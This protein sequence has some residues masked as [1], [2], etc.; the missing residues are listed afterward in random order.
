MRHVGRAGLHRHR[1]AQ[2]AHRGL[3]LRRALADAVRHDRQ[4]VVREQR[5]AL[6]LVQE[7]VLARRQR[8]RRILGPLRA[9][10]SHERGVR[11]DLRHGAEGFLFVGEGH[12]PRGAERI[13]D[14]RLRG[15]DGDRFSRGRG[16]CGGIARE[17]LDVV[18][19]ASD[20]DVDEEKVR[21]GILREQRQH[22]AEQAAVLQQRR[23]NVD[24]VRGRRKPRQP[25]G[26]RGLRLRRE[27]GERKAEIFREV[28]GHHAARARIA[29]YHQPPAFGSPALQV[30][31]GGESHGTRVAHAPD[32][33][34]AKKG[35]DH[36]VFVGER[37]GVRGRRLLSA[38]RARGFHRDDRYVAAV[39]IVGSARQQH[40]V[41]DGL[42]VKEDQL[43]LR[44]VRHGPRHVGDRDVR[45]V[46]R[47]VH[48]PHADAAAAH[49]PVYHLA[50][51]AALAHHR[52][53]PVLRLDLGEEGR[54][55]RDRAGAEVGEALGV[56]A[57][58]AHSG[59]A[60][61]L[62]HRPL[63]GPALLARLA[64]A[65]GEDHRDSHAPRGALVHSGDR[66]VAAHDDEHELGHLRQRGERGI[67][68]QPLDLGAV[69]IDRIDRAPEAVALHVK[70]RASA[71]L[72]RILRGADD[73][74][75]ARR[76]R[77]GEDFAQA[78]SAR[79]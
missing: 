5:E 7:A 55:V 72:V 2:I 36:P 77:A 69:R 29:H 66:G 11:G 67:A 12:Q 28:R 1:R 58:D 18:A 35:V 68:P 6:R 10:L 21:G 74:D 24:R 44:V 54:E 49:E 62:G 46:A 64:E 79:P 48:V 8:R 60:R 3:R 71:D 45:L 76:D 57:G 40:R 22:I 34:V 31:L 23:G 16:E 63:H 51:A 19:C 30:R 14:R 56:R 17:S 15:R 78:I 52:D 41:R 9:L 59:G 4:S 37:A 65:R 26:D 27:A 20:R 73:G 43:H 47:G 53:R 39:R 32:A 38:R 50:H 61:A 42:Q 25:G 70:D 75:R 33:M 13:R